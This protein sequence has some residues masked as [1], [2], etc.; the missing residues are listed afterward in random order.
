VVGVTVAT[1]TGLHLVL[2]LCVDEQIIKDHLEGAQTQHYKL[3]HIHMA[4]WFDIRN[5][6]S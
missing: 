5:T 6:Y 2:A 1:T 3:L 4:M